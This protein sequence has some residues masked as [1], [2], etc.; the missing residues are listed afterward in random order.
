MEEL[1]K[2]LL[3]EKRKREKEVEK[4]FRS[5]EELGL[6]RGD[7]VIC[8]D[9]E[10]IYIDDPEDVMIKFKNIAEVKRPVEWEEVEIKRPKRIGKTRSKKEDK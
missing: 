10:S 2:Y 5:A 8:K 7:L 1:L 9:G 3:E 6:R 4:N